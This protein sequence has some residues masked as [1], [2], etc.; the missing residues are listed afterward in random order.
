MFAEKRNTSQVVEKGEDRNFTTT[1][2]G[3]SKLNSTDFPNNSSVGRSRL[4]QAHEKMMN[5]KVMNP[6]RTAPAVVVSKPKQDAARREWPQPTVKE[7]EEKTWL[8]R[9]RSDSE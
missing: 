1:N 6:E 5:S 2:A 3:S 7:E 4:R 9:I 8:T